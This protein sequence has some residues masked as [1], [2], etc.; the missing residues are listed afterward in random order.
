MAA[1][2]RVLRGGDGARRRTIVVVAR[3]DRVHPG[4]GTAGAPRT[5]RCERE[6]SAGVLARSVFRTL[7]L[8][9]PW[10][11]VRLNCERDLRRASAMQ[12]GA[13]FD[14]FRKVGFRRAGPY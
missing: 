4:P 14:T 3:A 6:S 13:G 1:F 9:G 11:D 10:R 5:A 2:D 7:S 8:P 12:R